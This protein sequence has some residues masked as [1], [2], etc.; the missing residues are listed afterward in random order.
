MYSYTD[1]QTQCSNSDNK[2]V[3]INPT[4]TATISSNSPVCIGS[5][6]QLTGGP[7]GMSSYSWT[8]PNGFTS[9][10]QSPTIT[11]ATTAM[12]GD[13]ILTVTKD[14]CSDNATVAVSVRQCGGGGGGGGL[15]G[16][17]TSCPLTLTG[18]MLDTIA[19]TTMT[20][21]G[22]LCK[23]L[24]CSAGGHSLR[25]EKGTKVT[26]AGNKV[27]RLIK[28]S[29]SSVT[30][31]APADSTIV[32]Q[33]YQLEAY[34]YRY[35]GTP[36]PIT[37]SQPSLL[38]IDYDP[39]ELPENASEIFIAYYDTQTGWQQLATP[40][41][42]AEIG[43]ARGEVTHTTP[44]AVLVKTATP[45]RFEVSNLT[46][47]PSQAQLN[48]EVTISVDAANTGD[49]ASDYNMQLKVD[50][51]VKSSKLVTIAPGTSQTVNFTISGDTVGKHQVE[52]AG[53]NGEFEVA[54][55]NESEVAGQSQINWWLIGGITGAVLLIIIGIVVWRR[56]LRGY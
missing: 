7:D 27:P 14:T 45:A 50:G 37:M 41:G 20:Y 32:G 44:F 16:T 19:E 29:L 38:I 56:Q 22:V 17:T 40:G 26:L 30:P 5:I 46:V 6:I 2:T 24:L 49:T 15:R 10:L 21:E 55:L 39:N 1:P 33:V 18:D 3:T 25:I 36:S 13:Y 4:P 51:I 48:Q 47:S 53:L 35:G 52:I 8:G 9:N 11:G 43:S 23:T 34:A 28:F 54:G 42:P 31:P 12:S